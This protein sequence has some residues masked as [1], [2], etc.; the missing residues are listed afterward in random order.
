MNCR[1]GWVPVHRTS[2]RERILEQSI[3]GH[4]SQIHG[5]AA[6]ALHYHQALLSFNKFCTSCMTGTIFSLSHLLLLLLRLGAVHI[7]RQ[8][9]SG[10]PGPPL[11]PPS[12]MVSIWLTPPP[13]LVSFRQHLPNTPFLLQ[14]FT[15]TC[16]HDKMENFHLLRSNLHVI[17][18]CFNMNGKI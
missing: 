12:A 6:E 5:V 7:L 14:F 15:Q 4:H 2:N 3:L 10:V 16:L 1:S 9:K 11:P 13:P 17:W 8:P 18:L